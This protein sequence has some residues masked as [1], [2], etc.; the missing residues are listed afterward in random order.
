MGR[1]VFDAYYD[2]TP[3][4]ANPFR[5]T[6]SD[7]ETRVLLME[8]PDRLQV[9]CGENARVEAAEIEMREVRGVE[10]WTSR[11][12]IETSTEE[13]AAKDQIERAFNDLQLFGDPLNE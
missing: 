11:V 4:V 1:Y 3:T 5:P 7:D 6:L 2:G 12:A 13:R 10:R 8:L 9:H